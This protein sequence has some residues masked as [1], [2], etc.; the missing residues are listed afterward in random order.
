LRSKAWEFL[1][2]RPK[3]GKQ[4]A[5]TAFRPEAPLEEKADLEEDDP[6]SLWDKLWLAISTGVLASRTKRLKT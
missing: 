3:I 6:S 1:F 2:S 5:N 4:E